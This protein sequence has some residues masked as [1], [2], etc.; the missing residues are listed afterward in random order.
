MDTAA[1]SVTKSFVRHEMN[2]LE[3]NTPV[4]HLFQVPAKQFQICTKQNRIYDISERKVCTVLF[5]MCNKQCIDYHS[6]QEGTT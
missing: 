3:M 5:T 6:T 1:I 2:K 4:I